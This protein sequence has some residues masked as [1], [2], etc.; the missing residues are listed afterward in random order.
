MPS[1]REGAE[2]SKS[3]RGIASPAT[4]DA[5]LP[6]P[7]GE[8]GKAA[9]SS[10]RNIGEHYEG[11]RVLLVVTKGSEAMQRYGQIHST[12]SYLNLDEPPVVGA[13][14]ST[15]GKYLKLRDTRGNVLLWISHEDLVP[16]LATPDPSVI[17]ATLTNYT[18]EDR[19]GHTHNFHVTN[20]E[21]HHYPFTPE[22]TAKIE[23][24]K[25]ELKASRIPGA[26]TLG[27]PPIPT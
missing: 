2:P 15:P 26:Q 11:V 25:T 6:T 13:D 27:Q 8:F 4:N 5:S 1:N 12:L 9:S 22:I 19:P 23:A 16:L 24:H 20:V 18:R 3:A 7:T 14:T 21:E 17:S 10:R